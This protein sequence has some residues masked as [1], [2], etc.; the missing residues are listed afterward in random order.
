MPDNEIVN[1]INFSESALVLVRAH[2]NE[3]E[4]L[5][6]ALDEHEKKYARNQSDPLYY[7]TKKELMAQSQ[8]HLSKVNA[9]INMYNLGK[10]E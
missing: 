6:D 9:L 4:R 10:G 3:L 5:I 1:Q 8:D 2:R 7:I